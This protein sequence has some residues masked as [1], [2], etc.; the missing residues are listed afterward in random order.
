MKCL[1]NKK[2]ISTY[3]INANINILCDVI[4]SVQIGKHVL[5]KPINKSIEIIL[6]TKKKCVL[7]LKM[8][9]SVVYDIFYVH[10]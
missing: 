9:V 10:K 6:L 3:K 4:F 8:N 1:I 7:Y 2:H 5:K